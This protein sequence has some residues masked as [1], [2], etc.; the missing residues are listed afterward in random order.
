MS[1]QTV[2]ISA[3]E[4]QLTTQSKIVLLQK[5]EIS[6]QAFVISQQIK[7]LAS[8]REIGRL[9]NEGLKRQI[10]RQK[11]VIILEGIGL[12]ALTILLL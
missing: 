4:T 9:K 7:Q 8:E 5:S 11:R 1:A 6:S 2:E 12:V 3:L 10:W